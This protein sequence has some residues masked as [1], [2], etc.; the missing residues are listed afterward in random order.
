MLMNRSNQFHN[1]IPRH[2]LQVRLHRHEMVLPLPQTP[3][4]L[5]QTIIVINN[6]V[7]TTTMR[8]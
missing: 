4:R 1:R 8:Y 7:N 5:D 3:S 6:H 2:A